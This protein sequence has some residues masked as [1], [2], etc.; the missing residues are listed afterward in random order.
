M[1]RKLPKI[2]KSL[3]ADT[4]PPPRKQPVRKRPATPL[5]MAFR[6]LRPNWRAYIDL[7]RMA[8]AE[9]D[10]DAVTLMRHW[11]RLKKREQ[12]ETTPEALCQL[13]S[14]KPSV[15]VGLVTEQAW[16]AGLGESTVVAA[17][18]H[19]RVM[20]AVA[21]R[22]KRPDGRPDAELFL[23][24]TGSLPDKKGAAVTINNNPSSLSAAFAQQTTPE[25]AAEP[26]DA[27]HPAQ[28]FRT[29]TSAVGSL[30]RLLSPKQAIPGPSVVEVE[31]ER[32]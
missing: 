28:G 25:A 11:N 29:M 21:T 19:P 15:L 8:A 9:G 13:A 20:K 12:L 30:D 1:P 5:S 18:E 24:A 16:N 27:P 4:P 17:L 14:M 32:V 3:S 26:Q 31:S 7:V 10:D 22:A 2:F 23:R 6:H